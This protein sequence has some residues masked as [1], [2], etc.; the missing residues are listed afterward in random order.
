MNRSPVITAGHRQGFRC[1]ARC[2]LGYGF[3]IG[4]VAAFDADKGG[5]ISA[6]WCG[7]RHNLAVSARYVRVSR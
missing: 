6:G 4:G 3:P 5:V 1:D 2:S 7:V